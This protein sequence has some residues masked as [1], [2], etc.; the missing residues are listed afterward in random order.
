[1]NI[2]ILDT[3]TKFLMY[4]SGFILCTYTFIAGCIEVKKQKN[5]YDLMFTLT[6]HKN[7]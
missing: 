1:M 5:N 7:D 3:I 2:E 4:G 6:G